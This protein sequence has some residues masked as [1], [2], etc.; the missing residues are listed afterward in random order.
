MRH[1]SAFFAVTGFLLVSGLHSCAPDLD[2][3]AEEATSQ[4]NSTEISSTPR[5]V[6]EPKRTG[7]WHPIRGVNEA[8][9][10]DDDETA[11]LAAM[12]YAGAYSEA[13]EDT[14]ATLHDLSRCQPGLTLF[15]SGHT[16]SV[17]LIDANGEIVHRWDIRFDDIWPDG[18]G[19]KFNPIHKQFIRRAILEP[20]GD[21]LVIFEYVGIAKVDKN[22][23][24]YWAHAARCHHDI[25][26]LPDGRILT[27]GMRKLNSKK[28][29]EKFPGLDMPNGLWDNTLLILDSTGSVLR[30][31][32][33]TDAFYKS[34]YGVFLSER[35]WDLPDLLHVNSIHL[36]DEKTAQAH[37]QFKKGNVLLSIRNSSS[38]AILNI[39]SRRIT[40]LEVGQ[41]KMQHQAIALEN[42]NILLMDNRGGNTARPL[43]QDRSRAIE[44]DPRTRLV[45]WQYPPTLEDRIFTNY[46]GYVQRLDNGNTLVTESTQGHILEIA[47]SGDLL[48]EFYSPFRAGENNELIP[49]IMGARRIDP[50]ELTFL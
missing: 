18:V 43:L 40:W 35:P 42:G 2:G 25:E 13:N 36:I 37:P 20:N 30:N 39:K 1:Q 7:I 24:P 22:S 5:E 41:W 10:A 33:I 8:K 4:A 27:L 17:Y 31:I 28:T 21:L 38:L 23:K 34:K 46:L 26:Q 32:S 29:L 47:P 49:T 11:S 15:C 19:F 12:G 6:A 14:G 3:A 44:Y 9:P 48:W 50:A 16:S 45:T